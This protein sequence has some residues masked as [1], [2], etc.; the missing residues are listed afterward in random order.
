MRK[1]SGRLS[2]VRCFLPRCSRIS[3]QA[4]CVV[5]QFDIGFNMSCGEGGCWVWRAQVQAFAGSEKK[6]WLNTCLVFQN[7]F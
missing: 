2:R 1:V 6:K 7:A 5:V 4:Q 3:A